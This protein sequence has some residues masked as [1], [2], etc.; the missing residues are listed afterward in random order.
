VQGGTPDGR[1]K[2]LARAVVRVEEDLGL[3]QLVD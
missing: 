3:N 1:R 2:Q